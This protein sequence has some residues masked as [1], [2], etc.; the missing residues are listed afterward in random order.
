MNSRVN[1]VQN[2]DR[3]KRLRDERS[4]L[5]F[6]ILTL[7]DAGGVSRGSQI[8]YEK[9]NPPTAD[10]LSCVADHGVDI[11]YVLTGRRDPGFI[12]QVNKPAPG[13]G[14][15][16]ALIGDDTG[17]ADLHHIPVY[18]VD[19]KAPDV[20]L[21]ETHGVLGSIALPSRWLGE[22]GI[23]PDMARLVPVRDD[24]MA[25]LIP[26]GSVAL[27]EVR[28]QDQ[29]PADG[30]YLVRLDGV[31]TIRRLQNSQDNET[32]GVVLLS[33]NQAYPPVFVAQDSERDMRLIASVHLVL[34][35]V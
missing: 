18:K 25:P 24:H 33:D 12:D 19:A 20:P 23:D 35:H 1:K 10:Y 5:G 28:S 22:Q 8:L 30:V 14:S 21:V 2:A 13:D 15:K 26:Q 31:L 7:A 6:T 11:L 4:R 3:G 34:S 27:V 32:P 9:G 17:E 29:R 16:S